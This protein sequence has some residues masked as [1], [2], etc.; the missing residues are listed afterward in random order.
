MIVYGLDLSLTGTGVA[1]IRGDCS[2]TNCVIKTATT[3]GNHIDRCL[4]IART[5]QSM[6]KRHPFREDIFVF[7]EDYAYGVSNKASQLA[8][9]GELNGIIKSMVLGYTKKYSVAVPIGTWKAFMG[10]G[11]LPKDEFKLAVFKKFGIECKTND[12][13]AAIGIADF[14]YALLTSKSFNGRTFT[15]KETK[16][17][18]T[19]TKKMNT[20]SK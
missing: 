5:I 4:T 18:Q 8:T 20:C 14:G 9:L 1:V 17:L 15:Q 12:E 6:L 3:D 10:N 7:N 11:Q 13:A 19:F 2:I 16:T